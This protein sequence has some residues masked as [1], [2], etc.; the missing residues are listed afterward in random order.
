[1][2]ELRREGK[3]CNLVLIGAGVEREPLEAL[4]RGLGL[5]D[6]VWFFGECYDDNLTA[7]M[8]YNADLCVAPGNVGLTAMHTMVYGTPVL[9]HGDFSRQ[10]PEFEAIR[11][12][13]TGNFFKRD[14]IMSLAAAIDD[15]LTNHM[16][17]DVT[18]RDCYEEI[19]T[20]WTPEYQLGVL[21]SVI[22]DN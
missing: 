19:D 6:N 10:M 8:I 9:T 17:R 15:W 11:P 22:R 18:R 4:S 7:S 5:D 1:M 20:N 13:K 12:G 2:N 16:D 21:K 3:N 14:D